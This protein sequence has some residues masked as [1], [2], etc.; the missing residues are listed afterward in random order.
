MKKTKF[1]TVIIFLM[2]I[3]FIIYSCDCQEADFSTLFDDVDSQNPCSG[4][5]P[6]EF[7]EVI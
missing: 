7:I 6:L 4:Y 5:A 1:I 3:T 2:S